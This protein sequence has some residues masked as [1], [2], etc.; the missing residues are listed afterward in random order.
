MFEANLA[1]VSEEVI[2]CTF[3]CYLTLY[4][5]S[6]GAQVGIFEGRGPIHEKGHIKTFKRRYGP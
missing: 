3:V 4:C 6:A 2:L 1:F 5:I